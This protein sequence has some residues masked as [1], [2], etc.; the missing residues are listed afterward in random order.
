MKNQ[1][2]HR[3][4]VVV[5]SSQD[6]HSA[7]FLCGL[8][9]GDMEGEACGVVPVGVLGDGSGASNMELWVKGLLRW[10]SQFT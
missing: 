7:F 10:Y 6:Y 5:A 9:P 1:G 4:E 3:A 2:L 8:S